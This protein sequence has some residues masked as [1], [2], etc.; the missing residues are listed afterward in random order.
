[1][2]KGNINHYTPLVFN[3]LSK[4]INVKFAYLSLI[5]YYTINDYLIV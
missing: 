3:S 2:K 1:M 4:K 5:N